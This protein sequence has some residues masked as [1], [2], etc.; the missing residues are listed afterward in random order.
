MKPVRTI[1]V[2]SFVFLFFV[3]LCSGC[4][5]DDEE[6]PTPSAPATYLGTF[7]CAGQNGTLTLSVIGSTSS[8]SADSINGTLR[9][10]VP[11]PSTIPLAGTL[12]HDT[13]AARGGGFRLS[14]VAS[15]FRLTG[16]L[17]NPSSSIGGFAT[18]I[19]SNNAGTTYCGTYTSQVAGQENGAFNLVIISVSV[20]GIAISVTGQNTTQLNGSVIGNVVNIPG[21]GTGT[22]NGNS[23]NGSFDTGAN[24]GVWS[25]TVCQ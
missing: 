19:S 7:A 15:G 14:G 22:I 24:R 16:T 8:G 5:K 6:S 25:A 18:Q 12:N 1:R 23:I 13:L 11:S 20:A 2:S 9:L 21:V 10:I 4:T 3:V 17:V